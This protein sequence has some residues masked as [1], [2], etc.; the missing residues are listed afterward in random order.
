M[1]AGEDTSAVDAEI[2]RYLGEQ[3]PA[4]V[5]GIRGF[6]RQ[7]EAIAAAATEEAARLS[8]IAAARLARVARLKEYLLF[9]LQAAGKTK[10]EGRTGG[11][12]SVCAN[13]G[14]Q[15]LV[16]DSSLLPDHFCDSVR[17]PNTIRIRAALEHPCATC[18]GSKD[19]PADPRQFAD[20]CPAC[21]ASGKQGVPGA[22]LDPRGQ[23]VRIK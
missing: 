9:A 10:L 12:I 5:D 2:A 4:K 13:G 22:H 11:S 3:L 15:P 16:I 1:A 18:G 20:S 19:D 6:V 14:V 17:T 7:E 23:H 8:Q 21:G